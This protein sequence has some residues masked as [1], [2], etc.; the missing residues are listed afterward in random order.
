LLSFF[1]VNNLGLHNPSVNR[2]SQKL[3][4]IYTAVVYPKTPPWE[5]LLLSVSALYIRRA[6]MV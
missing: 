5:I 4:H 3:Y 2:K 1:I 6:G